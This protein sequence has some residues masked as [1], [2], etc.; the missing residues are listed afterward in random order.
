MSSTLRDFILPLYTNNR[1]MLSSRILVLPAVALLLAA[2]GPTDSQHVTGPALN[3]SYEDVARGSAEAG[4]L[5]ELVSLDRRSLPVATGMDGG[6]VIEVTGGDLDLREDGTYRLRLSS[7]SICDGDAHAHSPADDVIAE[8][9]YSLT[10]FSLRFGDKML[11]ANREP[12]PETIEGP[13]ELVY[14][15][16]PGRRMA[17]VGS[18]RVDRVSFTVE[19][20][21]TYTFVRS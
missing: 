21:R 19:D 1:S 2:C 14:Q 18:M 12:A 7:R 20:L 13:D 9:L 5:F 10:G 16:L 6:C 17:A 15:L 4:G 3:V 11:V 8:G